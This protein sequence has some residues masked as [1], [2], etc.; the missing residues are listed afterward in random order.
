MNT[1]RPNLNG[2]ICPCCG[3]AARARGVCKATFQA[4]LRMVQRKE[5][6]WDALECAGRV[7]PAA[8]KR[9][10]RLTPRVRYL[11]GVELARIDQDEL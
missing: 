4:A 7:L 8:S 11:L 6:T 5:T 2:L 10:S 1:T 9:R 3:T